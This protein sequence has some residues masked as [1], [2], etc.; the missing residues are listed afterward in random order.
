MNTIPNSRAELTFQEL[1]AK[2]TLTPTWT[3]KQQLELE[4]AR[5][6]AIEMLSVAELMRDGRVDP[7]TCLKMLRYAK[8]LDFL[9]TTLAARRDIKPQTLRVI[10]NLAGLK[11]GLHKSCRN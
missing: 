2:L 10:F 11:E 1:L 4:M 3:E 8:V 5:D 7:E 9:I 6:I